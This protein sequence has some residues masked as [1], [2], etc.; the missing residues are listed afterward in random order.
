MRTLLINHEFPPVGGGA[1]VA[2]EY[3]VKYL[4]REGDEAV[5]LTSAFY[6]LPQQEK[7]GNCIIRRIFANR[8]EA[9]TGR[10]I[11]YILF[12][13]NGFIFLRNETKNIKPEIVYAFFTVPAGI[14]ALFIKKRYNIPYCLFLRGSVDLPGFYPGRFGFLNKLALPIIKYVWINADKVIANSQSLRE[15]AYNNFIKRKIYVIPNGVDT[16]V[17][18]PTKRI[19]NNKFIKIISIG[20]L[21]R[22]K[23]I[24]YMLE[25]ISMIRSDYIRPFILEI[26]GDGPEKNKLIK[27][28]SRFKISDRVIFSGWSKREDI[29]S[30]YQNADI[31]ITVSLIEGMPNTLLEAMSCGL[32][33]IAS[34]IPAHKE[35]I[36][37][38]KNGLLFPVKNAYSLSEA[39]RILIND[40]ILRMK[41]G[42]ENIAKTK[43][44]SW[45][46]TFLHLQNLIKKA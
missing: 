37:N 22:Q 33:V 25:A 6:N 24:D 23:G 12:I 7:K 28:C 11:E 32:P 27:K 13:I 36:I 35:L 5:V 3:I 41:M 45:Q 1:S 4:M 30:K 40:D 21:S 18:H 29:A 26:V 44:Y 20:R 10:V 8:K 46:N 19:K 14:L 42:E 15:L 31:F 43:M 17:F 2:C 39:V 38:N 34:D 9:H 16:N